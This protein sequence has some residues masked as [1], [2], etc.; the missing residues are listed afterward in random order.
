M[1]QSITTFSSKSMIKQIQLRGISRTPSDKM[2]EDGGLSESLNMYLDTAEQAPAL[3]PEDVTGKLGLPVD[4]EAE[5]I[6]IHKT[7][8]YKNYIVVQSYKV[9]AYTPGIEDEEPLPVMEL[10]EGETV[11]DITSV[12]NT[13]VITTTSSLYYI[14][15]KER[16]YV[17]LGE[18][19]PF[20]SLE[21]FD[22][23]TEIKPAPKVLDYSLNDITTSIGTQYLN[24]RDTLINENGCYAVGTLYQRYDMDPTDLDY[25]RIGFYDY[26]WNEVDENGNNTN[27]EVLSA[28]NSIKGLYDKMKEENRKLSIFTN[29]IWACY[30]VRLFN[31]SLLVSTPQLISPGIEDPIE[32]CGFGGFVL[33]YGE[34]MLR[35]N[36]FYK[37]GV[38]IL[39]ANG[40]VADQWKDIIK[41]IEIFISEDINRFDIGSITIQNRESFQ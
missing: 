23:R 2:S 21:F 36:H 24:Q 33:G 1:E 39:D 11:N 5:R 31:D 15:Y 41:G 27:P 7:A 4:L 17:F 29:P 25:V 6:F 28:I 30:A 34:I 18:N 26:M 12:G 37:L 3:V 10:A 19:V 9:V 8:N 14:L 40:A 16:N 20:P 35:L 38:R 32:L 22:V 13:L